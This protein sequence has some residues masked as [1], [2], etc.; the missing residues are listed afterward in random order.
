MKNK[1]LLTL[2]ILLIVPI[3][4]AEGGLE[5]NPLLL[6]TVTKTGVAA[7]E[8]VKVKNLGLDTV[9]V[10][11]TTGDA[12]FK[13]SSY[14]FGLLP[15]EE[16]V[17]DFSFSTKLPGVFTNEFFIRTEKSLD[18]LPVVV[19]VETP[20]ARF[21]STV[22]TLNAKKNFYPGD[23]I[24]FSFTVFDLLEFTQ[25]SVEMEYYILDMSNALVYDYEETIDVKSQKTL[26]RTA[27]LP[28]DLKPGSYVLAVK[29]RYSTSIGLSTLLFNVVEKPKAVEK[30]SFK[31]F[32]YTLVG[33]CSNNSACASVT[34]SV[35]FIILAALLVY[36]IEVIKL[37]KL[38]KKKIEKALKHE[39]RKKRTISLVK[40][41]LQEAEEQR[42]A[43]EKEKTEETERESI[44]EDMLL[45][46]KKTKPSVTEQKL[47]EREVKQYAK[48]R[49]KVLKEKKKR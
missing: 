14:G 16:K 36:I 20:S 3:A 17:L 11:I 31:N 46:K 24:G 37:S 33:K 8:F 23:E 25:T 6:K 13:L 41:I 4:Y 45:K 49:K 43:R 19:E 26:T 9:A 34:I 48:D 39:E 42:Q 28:E 18:V 2:L 21:D 47:F 38:P 40:E 12:N 32:S 15:D 22:E 7:Q 29:S 1:L 27:K 35:A 10:Q 44:I 5:V 30:W